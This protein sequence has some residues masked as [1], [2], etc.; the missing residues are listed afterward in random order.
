MLSLWR[1]PMNG[2]ILQMFCYEKFQQS[3][4]WICSRSTNRRLVVFRTKLAYNLCS[5]PHF[6]VMHSLKLFF[7]AYTI[8]WL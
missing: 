7:Q 8:V 3:W 2:L 1:T 4:N 5:T 6:A